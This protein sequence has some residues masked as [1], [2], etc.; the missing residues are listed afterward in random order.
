MF[1]RHDHYM[2]YGALATGKCSADVNGTTP[3]LCG[4]GL[5]ARRVRSTERLHVPAAENEDL[6]L[7]AATCMHARGQSVPRRQLKAPVAT[8]CLSSRAVCSAA[9]RHARYVR[10]VGMAL[11][12]AVARAGK[13]DALPCSKRDAMTSD[14]S[15]LTLTLVTRPKRTERGAS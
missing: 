12:H 14:R 9:A 10:L 7:G 8:S 5:R 11:E 3:V 15:P 6:D 13:R 2:E 4:L 1:G